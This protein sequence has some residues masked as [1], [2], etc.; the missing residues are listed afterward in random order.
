MSHITHVIYDHAG[1]AISIT[2]IMWRVAA[3]FLIARIVPVMRLDFALARPQYRRLAYLFLVW[4]LTGIFVAL[5]SIIT[6]FCRI[7]SCGFI[8]MV[9]I[10]SHLQGFFLFLSAYLISLIYRDKP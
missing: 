9:D 4:G 8:Y 7:D 1:H 3:I 6:T 2:G 5:F 10:S